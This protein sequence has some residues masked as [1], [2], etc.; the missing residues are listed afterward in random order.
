MRELPL[1]SNTALSILLPVI[2]QLAFDYIPS[3]WERTGTILVG[4]GGGWT[5]VDRK[6][7]ARSSRSLPSITSRF[8]LS[9]VPVEP[10]A[11]PNGLGAVWASKE[12]SLILDARGKAIIYNYRG[13][14]CAAIGPAER[15]M[16]QIILD[17]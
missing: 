17:F 8:I 16:P 13:E 5:R 15:A 7:G 14:V 10:G 4:N 6:R 2:C 12:G 3:E 9:I 11:D 1:L